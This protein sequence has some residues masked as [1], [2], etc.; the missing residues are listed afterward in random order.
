VVRRLDLDLAGWPPELDGLRI[1]AVADLH[2]GSGYM[3]TARVRRV[4]ERLNGESPDLVA[5]LGDYADASGADAKAQEAAA[6]AELG[7]LRARLG[8]YAVLGNH[9]LAVGGRRAAAMLRETG[10]PVLRNGAFD[11]A[12]LW[13]VGVDDPNRGTARVGEAFRNVP[14]GAAAIVLSH[15]PDLF[16][17]LPDEARLTLSGPTTGAQVALPLVDELIAPTRRGYVSGLVRD[18]GKTLYVSRGVGTSHL[19]LRFRAPPEIAL[20]TLRP[21]PAQPAEPAASG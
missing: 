6:I 9:D 8:V 12:G 19:P 15:D 1:G 14:D 7:R 20:L 2:T 11:L 13:L 16:P 5:L 4:V 17:R 21:S 18:G 10:I 3:D